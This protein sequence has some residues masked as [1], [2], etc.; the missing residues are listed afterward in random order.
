MSTEL[1]N[2]LG[3]IEGI[4]KAYGLAKLGP[5]IGA[6]RRQLEDGVGIE[7]AVL[8]RFK[9]GKSSFL[10]HMTGHPVLP[11]GV[12]PLTAVVTRIRFG[13]SERVEV[14]FLDGRRESV[15][16][17]QVAKYVD[18]RENPQNE[19]KVASV[20][21]ELP[22]LRDFIPLQF[23]D[24]PGVGSAFTHNTEVALGWL[25]NAGAAL[26]AVSCDAPLSERDLGLLY[27]L[28]R[29]TP[30]IVLLLT[31]ADLLT[32]EQRAEVLAFVQKE[33]GAKGWRDMPVYF[34]SVHPEEY[35]LKERLAKELLLPLAR[36]GGASAQEIARHKLRSL[37]DQCLGYLHVA[38]ASAAQAE[39]AQKALRKKL[40]EEWRNFGLLRTELEL[41]GRESSAKALDSYL[42]N[43]AGTQKELQQRVTSSLG[44]KMANW[45]LRLPPLLEAWRKWMDGFLREALITVSGNE[46]E[47]FCT[48]L[49]HAQRHLTRTV[50]AFHDRL[51]TEVKE[52]LGVVLPT[53]EFTLELPQTTAPPVDVSYGMD[54]A[55][56][57]IGWIVPMRLFHAP[58]ERVLLRKARWEVEKNL[59]RLA[60]D[61]RDRVD[62]GIRELTRQ[63]ETQ[64]AMEWQTLARMTTHWESKT[65]ELRETITRLADIQ[66]V[67]SEKKGGGK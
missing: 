20:E 34:Y 42:Q 47:M 4:A 38:L 52:A 6:C 41:L 9:A 50:R 37:A 40:E 67:L 36:H 62:A 33:L 53:S 15:S 22:E 25:P 8:G 23:V 54:A 27:E 16:L 39:E 44:Q 29:H 55:F 65:P 58:V 48:P 17:N 64:A 57:A 24:T 31:K 59:S 32:E 3:G 7:V 11:I 18:E 12:V 56:S 49:V 26:V 21:I 35:G 60:A 66:C 19:K 2:I 51:R 5:Q 28:R 61:W 43:L 63:A 13:E 1:C 10:N 46:R 30:R 45:R 14:Y